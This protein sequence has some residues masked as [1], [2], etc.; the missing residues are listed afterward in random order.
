MEPDILSFIINGLLGLA[1]YFM[2]ISNDARNDEV[3]TL[4]EDLKL[5]HDTY[6]KKEDFREFK[7]ELWVRLDKMEV[8]FEKRQTYHEKN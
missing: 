2:K 1:M 7:E 8:N 4:K 5:V 3:K 6:F